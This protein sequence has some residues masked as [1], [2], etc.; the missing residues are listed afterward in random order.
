MHEM[1]RLKIFMRLP[2]LSPWVEILKVQCGALREQ[3]SFVTVT[4]SACGGIVHQG[5]F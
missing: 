3:I 4:L 5:D 2:G 1:Q